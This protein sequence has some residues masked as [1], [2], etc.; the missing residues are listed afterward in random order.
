MQCSVCGS[1]ISEDTKFCRKCGAKIEY[2]NELVPKEKL[3]IVKGSYEKDKAILTFTYKDKM[4]DTSV[5]KNLAVEQWAYPMMY[6]GSKW[7]GLYE[8]LS[9][10]VGKEE[11]ALQFNSDEKSFHTIKTAMSGH[12]VKMVG[13]DNWVVIK[14]SEN[15]FTTNIEINGRR[16]DIELIKSRCIDEWISSFSIRDIKWDGIF[17]ELAKIIGVD[18]YNINFEGD[19]TFMEMLI[20]NCPEGINIFYH[21]SPKKEQDSMKSRTEKNSTGNT[22][23]QYRANNNRSSDGGNQ[24]EQKPDLG[25]INME[26]MKNV[27]GKLKESMASSETIENNDNI[28]IKNK[29]IRNNIMTICAA[30]SLVFLFL[31]FVSFTGEVAG[32]SQKL[33]SSSGME[34]IFGI[35][36]LKV[37]TN[38]SIFAIFLL[39][40]PVVMIVMN[41]IKPLNPYKKIIAVALPV[42]GIIMEIVTLL[43]IRSIINSFIDLTPGVE[44]NMVHTSI[45]IGFI[46]LIVS[47]VLM[48]VCGLMIYH[49]FKLPKKNK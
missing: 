34:A 12:P 17:D 10:F 4:F 37:G 45:G 22:N 18:T 1:E 7:N 40:V 8:E 32:A 31:P 13:M 38:T 25:T 35:K 15:P 27:A 43:D 42:V 3:E 44:R 30:I 5:I 33:V 29:F 36:D 16:C 47:F 49:N 2:Q 48:T 41:Y 6:N 23:K 28:P 46:L 26:S 20:D 9:R 24:S 21:T 11:F 19:Q 39:I 14:Y